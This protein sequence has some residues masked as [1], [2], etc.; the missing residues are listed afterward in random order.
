MNGIGFVNFLFHFIFAAQKFT[1][2]FLVPK[3]A[4][5]IRTIRED[6]L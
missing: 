1:L 4:I 3:H 5:R 6:N 2:E